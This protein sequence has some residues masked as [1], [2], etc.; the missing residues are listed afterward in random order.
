VNGLAGAAVS[1]ALRDIIL[2]AGLS[3]PL[4]LEALYK[5][6]FL[7]AT[8][9][10]DGSVTFDGK[11]YASLSTAAGMAQK[12]VIGAPSGRPYP[13]TNGWTFWKFKDPKSGRLTTMDALRKPGR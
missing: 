11:S 2:R 4:E 5:K 7:T 9:R 10:E 6:R 3:F 13:Q 1:L 8:V 12:T